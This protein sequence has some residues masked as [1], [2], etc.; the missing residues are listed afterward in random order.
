[1]RRKCGPRHGERR[2]GYLRLARAGFAVGRVRL[3]GKAF[4][5]ARRFG[6]D[7]MADRRNRAPMR[8]CK[9]RRLAADPRGS[10]ACCFSG[11]V[12]RLRIVC[13][14]CVRGFVGRLRKRIAALRNR[15]DGRLRQIERDEQRPARACRTRF[16]LAADFLVIT[17]VAAKMPEEGLNVA[18]RTH[19]A[20][21]LFMSI[22][23]CAARFCPR[24]SPV[25]NPP[26]SR[27]YARSRPSRNSMVAYSSNSLA[28]TTDRPSAPS[29]LSH[30]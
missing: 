2:C 27:V 26:C 13:R 22:L 11:R 5:A 3:R 24:P 15:R 25:K 10:G 29:A 4:S 1:M 9:E 14:R 18:R 16:V 19:V 28:W 23:C 21:V 7:G 6:L 30:V 12:C 8:P 20:A 17:G